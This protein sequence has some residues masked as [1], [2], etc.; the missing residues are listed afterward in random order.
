MKDES[1]RSISVARLFPEKNRTTDNI[2]YN[3][4]RVLLPTATD[5]YINAVY[6]RVSKLTYNTVLFL[7]KNLSRNW[8]PDVRFSYSPK[9]QWQIQSRIS[10]AWYGPKS[11]EQ[12]YAFTVLQRYYICLKCVCTVSNI[13]LWFQM[14]DPFFPQEL[15]T[16]VNYGDISATVQRVF[17]LSHCVERSVRV[18]MHGSDVILN[19]SILQI[20]AWPKK[21]IIL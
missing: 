11:P 21:Y 12:L 20:K 10:G 17:D 19:I 14:L 9:R 2:P 4:S 16:E 7:L 1:K 15:N 5:D 3:H 18:T 8:V 13:F 6:V